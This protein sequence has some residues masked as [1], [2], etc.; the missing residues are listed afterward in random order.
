[1]L[2]RPAGLAALTAPTMEQALLCQ[3][4]FELLVRLRPQ[5]RCLY[6]ALAGRPGSLQ[7]G[8]ASNAPGRC[9][10]RYSGAVR[11]RCHPCLQ[12]GQGL[13]RNNE[14]ASLRAIKLDD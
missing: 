11:I 12:I 1:M 6:L 14:R 7:R 5:S 10:H 9:N 8:V 13:L 3:Y 2:C 4:V